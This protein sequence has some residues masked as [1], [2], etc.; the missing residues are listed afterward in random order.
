MHKY[1]YIP[2]RNQGQLKLLFERNL[3]ESDGWWKANSSKMQLAG[4]ERMTVRNYQVPNS[5]SAQQTHF[6]DPWNCAVQSIA[7]TENH[8]WSDEQCGSEYELASDV[9]RGYPSVGDPWE[10]YRSIISE[11][12]ANHTISELKSIMQQQYGFTAR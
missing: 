2:Y 6:M 7:F 3:S 5:T 11:L 4:R 9:V 12:Y 8:S 10:R 1:G